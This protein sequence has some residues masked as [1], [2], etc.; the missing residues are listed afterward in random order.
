MDQP[1]A[2]SSW[3][4][5]A[6]LYLLQPRN[7]FPFAAVVLLIAAPFLYRGHRIA[8]VPEADEPFDVDEFLKLDVPDER[9]A[10]VEYRQAAKLM[11]RRN[12]SDKRCSFVSW[13][14][15]YRE[16]EVTD[17]HK[18]WLMANKQTLLVWRRG[19]E[20]PDALATHPCNLIALKRSALDYPPDMYSL[21]VLKAEQLASEGKPAEA[22]NWL[23]AGLR[24]SAHLARNCR[25]R[26]R[27]DAAWCRSEI[28]GAMVA[29]SH[30]PRVTA[31]QLRSAL[32]DVRE[33]VRHVPPPS[34][35]LK[36]EYL[37]WKR[38]LDQPDVRE[39]AAHDIFPMPPTEAQ[40]RA[41]RATL[42]S[43]GEPERTRMLIRHAFANWFE[44]VD[45]PYNT[46]RYSTGQQVY[47]RQDPQSAMTSEE[48]TTEL[49]RTGL[50]GWLLP[51]VGGLDNCVALERT[52][53]AAL[54]MA[55]ACQ[56]YYRDHQRFPGNVQELLTGYLDEIP[57]DPCAE[58]GR[59]MNYRKT[60]SGAVVWGVGLDRIDQ[61][62]GF[63]GFSRD[64]GYE[65]R[66]PG[67]PP[68][69]RVVADPCAR[70]RRTPAQIR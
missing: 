59:P 70:A 44:N 23:L 66:I 6:V 24:F 43:L 13:R 5:R 50:A 16:G 30:N 7:A 1:A 25:L 34:R 45:Q 9:N 69:K 65:L 21:V 10:F 64:C 32:H 22:W 38:Y 51:A 68:P 54:E 48:L 49:C 53:H 33:T 47:Q 61:G 52:R 40:A 15:G 28:C 29:W 60:A 12:Y 57:K 8:Q 17:C 4:S 19:T 35:T 27:C 67:A 14:N 55:L 39:T 18:S 11:V 62:G 26:K 63:D 36:F 42:Y 3:I 41:M 37:A 56:R 20:K 31:G 58:P 46:K 2:S